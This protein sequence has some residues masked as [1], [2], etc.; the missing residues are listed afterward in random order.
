MIN[1]LR[2]VEGLSIKPDRIFH[3]ATHDE[4]LEGATTDIYFVRTRE[5]L[6]S[7]GKENIEVTAEIFAS[8][9]GVLAGVEE[10]LN[11]LKKKKVSVWA[12]PEKEEIELRKWSCALAARTMSSVFTKQRSWAF[13]PVPAAGPPLPKHAWKRPGEGCDLL[14][15]TACPPRCGPGDGAVRYGGR[16]AGCSCI[17]GANYTVLSLQGQSRTP[18]SSSLAI[19]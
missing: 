4:I 11:L 6:S 13:W 9:A 1:T 2:N 8:R 3:S 17:L 14:W 15:G 12:I 5:L 10:A 19:L 18:P 7:L 16:A